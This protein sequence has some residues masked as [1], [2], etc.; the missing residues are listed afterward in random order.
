MMIPSVEKCLEVIREVGMPEHILEHSL[1]VE[2]VARVLCLAHLEKGVPLSLEKASAGALL[3]DIAKAEC[4]HSDRD[5]A[6][7]GGEICSSKG[8]WE[9]AEI[10]AEHVRLSNYTP[11]GPV[12]EK[13]IVYYADKRVNHNRVVSL[14]ERLS[15]LIVRY[16]G[17]SEEAAARIQKNFRLCRDLERKLF[18]GL[19]FGPGDLPRILATDKSGEREAFK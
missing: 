6:E 1:M 4:L 17:G 7:V 11:D 8:F 15:D 3:H 16:A 18:S 13:E 14:D 9:I 12:T 5:H 19:N 10:I 2:R